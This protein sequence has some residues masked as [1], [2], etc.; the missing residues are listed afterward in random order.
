ME[1]R[2]PMFRWGDYLG[3]LGGPYVITGT[4]HSPRGRPKHRSQRRDVRRTGC[5][6]L[7]SFEEEGW[8]P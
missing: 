1:L 3:L 8:G 4:P 2:L 6:T 7:A 5:S